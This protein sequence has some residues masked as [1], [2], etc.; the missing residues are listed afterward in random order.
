M[1]NR[2][3]RAWEWSDHTLYSIIQRQVRLHL[4]THDQQIPGNKG[5]TAPPTAAVVLALF[6]PVALL[7]LGIG[8]QQVAQIYGVQPYHLPLCDALGLNYSWYAV[9]SAQKNR[10]GIQTP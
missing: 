5:L 9:P 3:H 8:D 2:R 4:R 10:R 7:Q 1:S 6:A